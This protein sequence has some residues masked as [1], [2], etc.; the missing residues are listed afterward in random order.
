MFSIRERKGKSGEVSYQIT[1]KIV[2]FN[3]KPFQKAKTWKPSYKMT[4]KQLQL[5]VNRIA[6]EFEREVEIQFAGRQEAVATA[7]TLFNEFAQYW[8]KKIEKTCAASYFVSAQIAFNKIEKI[9]KGYRLKDLVPSVLEEIHKK[10]DDM[11]KVEY[12]VVA[13]DL[14]GEE[15]SKLFKS[16][17]SF[18]RASGVGEQT[19]KDTLHKHNIYYATA[20]K[21]AIA[22]D[23]DIDDLFHVEKKE[24]PYKSSYTE[25]M[26][27][28]IRN[29]L[30]EAVQLGIIK[31]NYSR[32]L[33]ITTK[34]S[35]SE[36]VKSMTIADAQKLIQTCTQL[37]IRKRLI[38]SFILFTGVRKG[39]ICGLDWSDIDFEK[40]TVYIRRQYEAVSTK[41]C[42]LKEPKTKSS[43][44]KIE[45]SD[46]LIDIIKEYR[47]WYN[48][49]RNELG[50]QW[51]GE[52]SI[53][54]ARDGKRLHPT[55]V[56]NWLDEA[57]MLA[58]L[59][60]CSVHSLRHTNITIL[61]AS[62]VSPV[63]V[64]GRVGHAKV[65][66]TMD[67]YADFLGSSD[68]EASDKLNDYFEEK[69]TLKCTSDG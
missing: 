62:G 54:V 43:I 13:R 19:L 23:K 53:L 10:I 8:L 9:M 6:A 39:E 55:T 30:A 63:T 20:S 21:I 56:R 38:I 14:L 11:R 35:D 25:A 22:L 18:A 59:P 7:D 65:S 17:R 33:Y 50:E 5:A 60:H 67:I 45:L 1:V 44:R 32:R 36:K 27:K 66:T 68:K 47:E 58:G 2:G 4:G 37:D 64:A 51:Q 34:H 24:V 41:G 28:V 31:R 12:S 42:I 49:K 16:K 57:L 3:G 26:K 69:E 40:N 46:M 15:I 29:T 48:N 52:D 61:I